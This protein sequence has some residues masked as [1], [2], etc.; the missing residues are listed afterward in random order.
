MTRRIDDSHAPAKRT[1]KFGPGP[2]KRKFQLTD[3]WRCTKGKNTKT[4]YVQVC[5][6][7]GDGKRK[8]VKIKT[9]KSKKKTYNKVYRAFAKRSKRIAALTKRGPRRGYKCKRTK[10]ARCK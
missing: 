2:R 9:K 8:P 10:L 4:H 5:T 7:M 6:W 3:D 1:T